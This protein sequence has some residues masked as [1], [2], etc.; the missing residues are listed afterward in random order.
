MESLPDN[1]VSKKKFKKNNTQLLKN[2]REKRK[3]QS[4]DNTKIGIKSENS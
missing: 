1:S 4:M 3:Y 2:S